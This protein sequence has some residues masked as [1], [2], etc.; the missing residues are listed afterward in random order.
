[1]GFMGY[2]VVSILSVCNW[3]SLPVFNWNPSEPEQVQAP[4]D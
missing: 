3:V 1:M 2:I 4:S